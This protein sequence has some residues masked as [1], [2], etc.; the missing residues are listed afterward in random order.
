MNFHCLMISRHMPWEFLTFSMM[1]S[2]ENGFGGLNIPF[3]KCDEH[4]WH[5]KQ[6][7][8]P[9]APQVPKS[10][11]K[12]QK[13]P[14]LAVTR[15]KDRFPSDFLPFF[16]VY[17]KAPAGKQRSACVDPENRRFRRFSCSG[18]TRIFSRRGQAAQNFPKI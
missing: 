13:L 17:A 6:G 16:A 12:D 14:F 11:E 18:V 10:F 8:W 1:L 2:T 7:F 3:F 15:R 9:W 5:P 4:F